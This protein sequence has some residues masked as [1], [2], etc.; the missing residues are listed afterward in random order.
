MA[1][2]VQIV[3][4]VCFV[5]VSLA[6]VTPP[7]AAEDFFKNIADFGN[8]VQKA[9]TDTQESVVKS[10]GFQSNKDVVETLQNNTHK[11]V[12]QLKAVHTTLQK[13]AEKH[14][15]Q[16]EPVVKNLNAKLAETTQK[17]S[18]RNPA[19]VQKAK[20]Y[21]E[22]VQNSIQSLVTEAQKAGER[23]KEESRG[24]TDEL[25]TAL[26]QLFDLTVQNL[27]QTASELESKKTKT[28]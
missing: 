6:R 23:L 11:Y 17:L 12:E 27:Q 1:R 15:K 20:E 4:T 25:Q 16:I 2:L 9:L 13:H 28:V 21:Q 8:H 10:L 5:Q 14:S 7:A 3:L 22:S 24:A 26:K 19:L 18:E